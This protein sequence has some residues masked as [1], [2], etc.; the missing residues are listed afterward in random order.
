MKIEYVDAGELDI[1]ASD[2][3]GVQRLWRIPESQQPVIDG[4][5][6]EQIRIHRP[7]ADMESNK[8]VATCAY[9]GLSVSGQGIHFSSRNKATLAALEIIANIED[10]KWLIG[11]ARIRD[12]EPVYIVW[13]ERAG[14]WLKPQYEILHGETSAA[15]AERHA[16]SVPSGM[17]KVRGNHG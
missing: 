14:K 4:E 6:H 8:W 13:Y 10:M 17:E 9:T 12:D 1:K 15:A 3:Q 16:T 7:V 11:T 5:P 2:A